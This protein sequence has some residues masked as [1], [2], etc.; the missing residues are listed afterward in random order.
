[1]GFLEQLGY[2]YEKDGKLPGKLLPSENLEKTVRFF[3][4][5][6]LIIL[7]FI[8]EEK[9]EKGTKMS[10]KFFTDLRESISNDIEELKA[11]IEKPEY[12]P[13]Y[14]KYLNN[15]PIEHCRILLAENEEIYEKYESYLNYG[16]AYE[17]CDTLPKE[18]E[19]MFIASKTESQMI[20]EILEQYKS[21]FQLFFFK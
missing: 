12:C 13:K 7:R 17:G 4:A 21:V 11:N 8:E 20:H 2:L 6:I 1:M 3:E 9:K 5:I 18:H 10:I 15:I 16:L 19:D 14:H